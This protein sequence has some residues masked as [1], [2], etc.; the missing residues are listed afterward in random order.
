MYK[1]EMFIYADDLKRIGTYTFTSFTRLVTALKNKPL[2]EVCD[3]SI[4]YCG[5]RIVNCLTRWQ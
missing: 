4:I 2:Y 3:E 1:V 5:N